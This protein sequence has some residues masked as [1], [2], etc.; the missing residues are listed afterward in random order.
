MKKTEYIRKPISM[1]EEMM[2]A[3]RY[4]RTALLIAL[5]SLFRSLDIKPVH[6][7]LPPRL[8]QLYASEY[9]N[10]RC[11]MCPVAESMKR[12]QKIAKE[13]VD[14]AF[15]KKLV[16]G[17]G[18]FKPSIFLTGGEPLLNKEIINIIK[19][20]DEKRIIT[21]MTT[22][23]MLLKKCAKELV[24]T[25][26]SVVVV[27]IDGP[28]PAHDK[29][30]GVRGIYDSAVDGIKEVIKERNA[31]G[32]SFPKVNI[33]AVINSECID[34]MDHL[35]NLA[36][37]L[38]IDG[39]SF[40][41]PAFYNDKIANANKVYCAR[42]NIKADVIGMLCNKG[43]IRKEQM[44]KL[45]KFIEK[46]ERSENPKV[47]IKPFTDSLEDYYSHR[48]PGLMSSCYTI[49]DAGIIRGSGELEMCL[50]Y[51]I[52][53]VLDKPVPELWNNSHARKIRLLV[54]KHKIIP[55]CF[56]CCTLNF[57]FRI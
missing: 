41:H 40:Q 13:T 56:R 49:W 8:L 33:N 17:F 39:I 53:N 26:I 45:E 29:N 2:L 43:V 55:A 37:K 57:R 51:K 23:G 28:R 16:S 27:S 52:G 38:G 21:T 12:Q 54:K 47:F 10:A 5:H 11:A 4:P 22:N 34:D 32:K 35:L 24:N 42:H 44:K 30:R 9:C 14:M 3:F 25:G 31:A 7:L 18:V 36:K 6:A 46:A 20:F 50:G 15:V 1:K 48:L 19:Y